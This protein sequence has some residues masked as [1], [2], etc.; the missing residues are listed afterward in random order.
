[1]QPHGKALIIGTYPLGGGEKTK[2]MEPNSRLPRSARP[3]TGRRG[4]RQ[5]LCGFQMAG[6]PA[7]ALIWARLSEAPGVSDVGELPGRRLAGTFRQGNL[8]KFRRAVPIFMVESEGLGTLL[9]VRSVYAGASGGAGKVISG[10]CQGGG[11]RTDRR[12]RHSWSLAAVQENLR[13]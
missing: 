2:P 5:V 6:R 4:C 9:H 3:V 10:V 12:L 8:L 13:W 1:M 11:H 7:P